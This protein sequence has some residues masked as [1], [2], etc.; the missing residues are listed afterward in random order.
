MELNELLI[1]IATGFL[2]LF[3]LT[4][5][6]GRKEI[7]QMTFFNFVSAIAIGSIA[8]NLVVSS[9][10]SIRNGILALIGWTIFT[11][12]MDFIDIKSKKGR[13]VVTG[14][15]VIVIKEGKLVDKALRTS[16]LDLDSLNAMLRQQ[17]IFS[18]ADVDYAIFETNGKLS[19][20]RKEN[21][22]TV[23]KLDLNIPSKSKIYPIPTEVISDG[24]ILT[25]NLDKLNLDINWV[26]QQLKQFGVNSISDV[27]FAQIQTDGT[28]FIDKKE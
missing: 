25:N 13:M 14:S 4:R 24:I 2:V 20:Q 28:L 27:L 18:I 7:S 6:L 11:L 22:N 5:I 15:P 3:I 16:R 1:R 21:K 8:A 26:K 12:L 23:T 19:V 17:K 9:N 10:L